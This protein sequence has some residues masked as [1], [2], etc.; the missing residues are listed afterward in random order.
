MTENHEDPLK[1]HSIS[2]QIVKLYFLFGTK[3]HKSWSNIQIVFFFNF[4]VS[5]FAKFA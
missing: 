4:Y 1:K 5:L 2:N 3:M